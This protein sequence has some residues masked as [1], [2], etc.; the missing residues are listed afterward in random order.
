MRY[1][2]KGEIKIEIGDTE[3][4]RRHTEMKYKDE[5]IKREKGDTEKGEILKEI[6]DAERKRRHGERGDTKQRIVSEIKVRYREKKEVGRERRKRKSL[7]EREK[8]IQIQM[9]KWKD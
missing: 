3:R 4:N 6:G 2:N 5:E 8:K 1:G 7:G 9:E